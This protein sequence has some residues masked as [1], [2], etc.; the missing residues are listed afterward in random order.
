MPPTPRKTTPP[1]SASPTTST[2]TEASFGFPRITEL[3][4]TLEQAAKDH[5]LPQIQATLAELTPYLQTLQP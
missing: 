3:G 1:F 2:A 5:D 4:A